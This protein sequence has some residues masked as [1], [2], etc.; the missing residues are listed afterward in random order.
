MLRPEGNR[1]V[2][3]RT[4]KALDSTKFAAVRIEKHL[5][6]EPSAH[7][8]TEPREGRGRTART[9]PS[10]REKGKLSSRA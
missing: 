1:R 7:Q 5:G 2:K 6:N 10:L 8:K 9:R 3:K 4:R